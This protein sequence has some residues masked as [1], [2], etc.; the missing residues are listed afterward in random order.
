MANKNNKVNRFKTVMV[1]DFD[2]ADFSELRDSIKTEESGRVTDKE[3]FN[4]LLQSADREQIEELVLESKGSAKAA[5]SIE[6][7][8]KMKADLEAK[9]AATV[10]VAAPVASVEVTAPVASEKVA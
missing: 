7:L 2:R 8:Q 1:S 10:E 4:A 5:K 9:L 6:K 3:L